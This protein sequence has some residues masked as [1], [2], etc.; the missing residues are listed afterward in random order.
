MENLDR[1][2]RNKS[3]DVI[4]LMKNYDKYLKFVERKITL[5]VLEIQGKAFVD[6]TQFKAWKKFVK[7]GYPM[8]YK[9]HANRILAHEVLGT[10]YEIETHGI[11]ET[12]KDL[13][14]VNSD[15]DKAVIAIAKF[16]RHGKEFAETLIN[17][18]PKILEVYPEIKKALHVEN[19]VSA[20]RDEYNAKGMDESIEYLTKVLEGLPEGKK[21]AESV[22]YQL[23]MLEKIKGLRA[24]KE[25]VRK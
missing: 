15:T 13:I 25:N 16:S 12:I 9:G 21:P 8:N 20:N 23:E 19:V 14:Y 22:S 4:D 17:N 3:R 1:E 5:P 6:E 7:K 2:L 18:N 24:T 10:L 11:E